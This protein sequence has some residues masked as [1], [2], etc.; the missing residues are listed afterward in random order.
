SGSPASTTAA[1][2]TPAFS[3]PTATGS[4]NGPAPATTARAP[5]GTPEPLSGAGAGKIP[6][7]ERQRPVVRPRGQH[8]AGRVEPPGGRVQMAG[9]GEPDLGA[10]YELG[11]L[12]HQPAQPLED[13][14]VALPLAP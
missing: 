1:T 7:G 4:R 10:G 12:L 11:A 5:T 9:L 14:P 6:A 8:H 3:R 13:R 2:R